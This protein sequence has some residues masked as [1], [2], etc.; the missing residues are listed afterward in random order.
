MD[1]VL[2]TRSGP[3][4]RAAFD[5]QHRPDDATAGPRGSGS[6]GGPHDGFIVRDG[7]SVFRMG[8]V[9]RTFLNRAMAAVL[10][11]KAPALVSHRSAAY[12]HG[13]ERIGEPVLGRDHRAAAPPAPAPQPGVRV[14]ESLAFDLAEPT[15]RNGIPVTGVARTILDCRTDVR[16]ADPA[17]RRCAPAADRDVGRA[18]GLLSRPTTSLG[19]NVVPFQRILLERDGNTPPGGEFARQDGRHADGSRPADAGVRTP[20]CR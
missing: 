7:P 15:V 10:S 2:A 13:F 16:Q 14:H 6:T 9:P 11:S 3:G 19:R 18:L 4:R 12:L 1:E 17:A 8:G 20:R 5:G